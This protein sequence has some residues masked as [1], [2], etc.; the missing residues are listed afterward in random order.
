MMA[1]ADFETG[2][3]KS[4]QDGRTIVEIVP[5]EAC[6]S[7]SARILCR[8][9]NSGRHELAVLNPI[10]AEPGQT[11]QLA[12]TGNLLLILSLM[13]YGLPLLGLLCG[14]FLV[15]G[16]DPK[17]TGVRIE[18]IMAVAGLFGIILGGFLARMIL[19]HLS[20]TIDTV[21]RITAILPAGE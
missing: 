16:I 20:G 8:P 10:G 7:C 2:I 12:E 11:V 5:G 18:L 1:G 4:I 15:Y 19:R 17:I 14:V 13:Q 21:F 9:G 6:E 3:V